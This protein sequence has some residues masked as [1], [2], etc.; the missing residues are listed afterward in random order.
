MPRF[1]RVSGATAEEVLANRGSHALLFP[2][3]DRADLLKAA[4]PQLKW[5]TVTSGAETLDTLPYNEFAKLIGC[6]MRVPGIGFPSE[7]ASLMLL[8]WTA[9]GK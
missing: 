5:S 2:A 9:L 4:Q 1:M 8:P 6:A 3:E 7:R